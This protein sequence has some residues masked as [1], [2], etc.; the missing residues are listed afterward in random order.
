MLL[1]MYICRVLPDPQYLDLSP[2]QTVLH[3]LCASAG[4]VVLLKLSPIQHSVA[5]CRPMYPY[6]RLFARAAHSSGVMLELV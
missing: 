1:S 2:G 3:L 5:Y 4:L 6:C